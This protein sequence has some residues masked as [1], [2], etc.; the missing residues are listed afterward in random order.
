VSGEQSS[1]VLERPLHSGHRRQQST[2]TISQPASA[3]CTSLSEDYLAVGLSLLQARPSGTHY[4]PSFVVCPSVLATLDARWRRYC[5]HDISALSAVEMLCIILRYVNFLFYSILLFTVVPMHLGSGCCYC[6]LGLLSVGQC[7]WGVLDQVEIPQ[8]ERWSTVWGWCF[9][10]S[11]QFRDCL[12]AADVCCL[13]WTDQEW[14][15]KLICWC[16]CRWTSILQCC[17][18]D[19]IQ[20]GMLFFKMLNVKATIVPKMTESLRGH[21][22]NERRVRKRDKKVRRDV[23]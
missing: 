23:I 10:C 8:V 21:C 22:T 5:S 2:S 3:D 1:E 16:H 17:W 4:R 18:Y 19:K 12:F 15:S 6:P 7:G 11:F 9:M 13:N 14:W 20:S